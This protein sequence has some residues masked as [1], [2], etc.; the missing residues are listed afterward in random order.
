M[1]LS[2]SI[3]PMQPPPYT[4]YYPLPAATVGERFPKADDSAVAVLEPVPEQR[5][6]YLHCILYGLSNVEAEGYAILKELGAS[7]L[8]R[9][10]TCGGGSENPTWTKLRQ[11]LLGVPTSRAPRTDAALGAAL[12]ALGL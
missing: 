12:L 10:L 1:E 3:D 5:A 4:N 8:S 11:R 6:G 9:V 7:E 2:E